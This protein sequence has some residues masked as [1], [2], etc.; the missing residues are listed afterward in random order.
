MLI[1]TILGCLS[2]AH[3]SFNNVS[4]GSLMYLLMVQY[5]ASCGAVVPMIIYNP[6][7]VAAW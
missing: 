1:C 3:C 5:A 7:S 2:G 6:S 4:T